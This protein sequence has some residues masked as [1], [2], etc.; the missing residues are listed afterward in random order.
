M[1][2]DYTLEELQHLLRMAEQRE[3]AKPKAPSVS[4]KEGSLVN[5]I[6]E[7]GMAHSALVLQV[8]PNGLFKLKVFRQAQPNFEVEV[9]MARWRLR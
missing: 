4:V 8:K 9:T 3:A 5:Y 6:D 7:R 1:S 2:K